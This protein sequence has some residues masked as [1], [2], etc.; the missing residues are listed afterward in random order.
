MDLSK[1][2]IL[3]VSWL[4]GRAVGTTPTANLTSKWAR[5]LPRGDVMEEKWRAQGGQGKLPLRIRLA[6]I[7]NPTSFG[8]KEH[9]IAVLTATSASHGTASI[10]VF[11]VQILIYEQHLSAAT[12]ILSTLSIGLFGYGL[13]GLLQ[14]FTVWPSES[15]YWTNIPTVHTLQS[16]H[17][18]N[19]ATSK[20][21]RWFW[22]C[23]GA[24]ALYGE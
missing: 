14:P 3:I 20:R 10:S 9:A 4:F 23:A 18:D 13:T 16:F 22:I 19:W 8:I 1:T 5:F 12:V 7:F 2:L 11:T 6:K 17:W 24:M 15:V 21:M